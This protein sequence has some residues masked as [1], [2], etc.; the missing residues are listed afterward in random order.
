MR[1]RGVRSPLRL[2]SRF[3]PVQSRR[4]PALLAT[5][6]ETGASRVVATHGHAEALARY[7]GESGL[8][9]TVMRTAWEGE[10]GSDDSA[11]STLCR[12]LRR[13]RSHHVDSD[14]VEADGA[15]FAAA[16]AA[17]AAWAVY[18]LTGRRLK[19]LISSRA[20]GELDHGCHRTAR[21]ATRR[22]LRGRRRW[23]RNRRIALRRPPLRARSGQ[24]PGRSGSKDRFRACVRSRR[25]PRLPRCSPGWASCRA[26]NASSAQAAHRR[27]AGRRLADPGRPGTGP[28]CGVAHATSWR[29]G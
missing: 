7:L 12:A 14:K 29:R 16:P 10:A 27:A 6:R 19:R 20:I 11:M 9:A 3:R 23:R 15:Y 21:V 4:L 22:I 1:V 24:I 26:G 8:E 5:I 25:R 18:F 17:D 13:H 28:G 2:R